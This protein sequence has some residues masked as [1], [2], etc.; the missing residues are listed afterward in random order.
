MDQKWKEDP[1]DTTWRCLS[2]LP[3]PLLARPVAGICIGQF[4]K[5]VLDVLSTHVAHDIV[6]ESRELCDL[7]RSRERDTV[8]NLAKKAS[9]IGACK[10]KCVLQ[11]LLPRVAAHRAISTERV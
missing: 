11:T 5:R 6:A 8:S 7:R 10:F 1:W 4:C 9:K 2:R 3:K